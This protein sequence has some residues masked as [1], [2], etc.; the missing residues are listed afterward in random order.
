MDQTPKAN[1]RSLLRLAAGTLWAVFIGL[2]GWRKLP[3]TNQTP[4]TI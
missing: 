3:L 4:V 1:S 2:M